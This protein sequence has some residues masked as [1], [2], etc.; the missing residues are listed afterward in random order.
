MAKGKNTN[1]QSLAL[2]SRQNARV[3]INGNLN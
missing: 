3:N 2:R 1:F